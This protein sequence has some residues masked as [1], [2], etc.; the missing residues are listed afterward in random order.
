[1]VRPVYDESLIPDYEEQPA[2]SAKAKSA[3]LPLVF[4]GFSLILLSLLAGF[5]FWVKEMARD[6]D[7]NLEDEAQEQ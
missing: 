4:V 1:M 7:E 2:L 5:L 3:L 6:E